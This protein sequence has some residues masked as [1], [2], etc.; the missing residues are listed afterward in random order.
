MTSLIVCLRSSI[1]EHKRSNFQIHINQ[2]ARNPD[3][4]SFRFHSFYV[5]L[6]YAGVIRLF[7]LIG[8]SYWLVFGWVVRIIEQTHYDT[9]L[10]I[11]GLHLQIILTTP[12]SIVKTLLSSVRSFG[13]PWEY[14]PWDTRSSALIWVSSRKVWTTHGYILKTHKTNPHYPVML[15]WTQLRG[16]LYLGKKSTN[17]HEEVRFINSNCVDVLS[18]IY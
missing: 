12:H 8:H 5:T 4:H 3:W 15:W 17:M 18:W 7:F 1:H 6:R 9:Y 2:V 13:G 14:N 10:K 16:S 11:I